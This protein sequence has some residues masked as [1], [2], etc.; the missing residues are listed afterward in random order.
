MSQSGMRVTFGALAC[1]HSR[2]STRMLHRPVNNRIRE[3]VRDWSV[4]PGRAQ[5]LDFGPTLASE[6]PAKQL[7]V[8]ID[9]PVRPAGCEPR[10]VLA[11]APGA[12]G[13][14][15]RFAEGAREVAGAREA[16]GEGDLGE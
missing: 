15:E 12:R 10:S 1:S 14:A 9:E 6:M 8:Q 5:R 4:K 13:M 3:D 7:S 11:C 2:A 16:G